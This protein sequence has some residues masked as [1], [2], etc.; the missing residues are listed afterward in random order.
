MISRHGRCRQGRRGKVP[1]R[2]A[3]QATDVILGRFF[4]FFLAEYH[5]PPLRI[6][7]GGA[8]QEVAVTEIKGVGGAKAQS[9]VLL[10]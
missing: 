7:M 10:L 1:R 9:P 3:R 6:P 5:P 4:P 2:H 8:M